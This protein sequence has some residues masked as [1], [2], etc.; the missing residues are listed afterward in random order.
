MLKPDETPNGVS[1]K[2]LPIRL[3]CSNPLGQSP[4]NM[5]QFNSHKYEAG[6]TFS[7]D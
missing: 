4:Q 3:Q 2:I 1:I 6:H 7:G 5:S